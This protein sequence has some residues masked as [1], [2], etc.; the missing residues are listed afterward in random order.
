MSDG[1]VSLHTRNLKYGKLEGGMVVEVPPVLI[2][3]QKQHFHHIKELDVD[4]IFGN[5]GWVWVGCHVEPPLEDG[6]AVAADDA[7]AHTQN[8]FF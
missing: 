1:M 7:G 6:A 5:N 3:R 8:V 4:V 2:K